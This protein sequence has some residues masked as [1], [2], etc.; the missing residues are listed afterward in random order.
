M[1]GSIQDFV[2][3]KSIIFVGNSVEIMKHKH[4]K[5]I[6]SHDIVV[7]FGRAISAT[8]EQEES[9]GSRCDIWITGQFRAPEWHKNRENFEKGRFKDTRI[10][11][12]RC[13]G[14]FHLKNW[15]LED[16]LPKGMKYEFMYSDEEIINIMKSFDKDILRCK[17]LRPSAGFISILWFVNK[18]K[19]YKS[20]N[21]I[22]FDFFAKKVDNVL[23]KDKRG[24]K[25]NAAPH[26]WHLPVYLLTRSAHDAELEQQFM[27]FLK[28]RGDINWHI[29]SDLKDNQISYNDWMK[30]EKLTKTAP[31]KS[32]VSKILPRAQR[33]AQ[34]Q[35]L[36]G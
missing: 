7:R 22:G 25:S 20:L 34:S 6:E 5:F 1:V 24:V 19:T 27:Y 17:D 13:R 30:G 31:R 2:K 36:S 23:S 21:L 15:N 16:R 18:I 8:P 4:A 28:R 26:S 32:K 35:K 10:L 12:N 3:N 33:L 14:N 9:L 29:L 11:V